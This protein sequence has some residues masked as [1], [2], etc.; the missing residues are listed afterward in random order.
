M[1][2]RKPVI[3]MDLDET[4]L[5]F[6][7][8]EAAAIARTFRELGLPDTQEVIDR[9]SQINREQW[10]LMEEGL[11]TRD[12]VLVRRFHVLFEELG[13]RGSGAATRDLYEGYLARGHWFVP[14]AQELLE[15]L[16]ERYELC[17]AS[18]GT[19]AVQAGRIASA[20]IARFFSNIFI[21]QELGANKPDAA[22]FEA[23]FARIPGFDRDRCLIL[24]D[25][26]GSDIR[27]GINAGILTCWF[28]PKGLPGRADIRPDY[29]IRRLEELPPLLERIWG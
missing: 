10:G 24:G 3:L 17:I 21:S 20:G 7:Q 4:I 8:A 15:T 11:I 6:H 14:G 9:Y 27:G 23:C 1:N 29:E 18:N 19:A 13:V 5:D 26:L 16:W 22:F 2:A 25:G 28:N 12:Q